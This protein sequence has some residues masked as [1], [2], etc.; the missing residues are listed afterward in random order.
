MEEREEREEKKKRHGLK[1]KK[2]KMKMI[3]SIRRRSTV[4]MVCSIVVCSIF[5]F[6]FLSLVLCFLS[7]SPDTLQIEFGFATTSHFEMVAKFL[8]FFL[9]FSVYVYILPFITNKTNHI[10]FFVF[11]KITLS[12]LYLIFL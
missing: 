2:R 11:G 7:S 5:L 4:T 8:F 6:L 1:R 3:R 12:V 9:P 10:L